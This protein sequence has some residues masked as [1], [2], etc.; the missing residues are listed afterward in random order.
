VADNDN[1]ISYVST[2][3]YAPNGA[4]TSLTNGSSNIL[5]SLAYNNRQQLCRV[6][7]NTSG[8]APTSCTDS[9]TGNVMDL[10]FS[11]VSGN[12]GNIAAENNNVSGASGRTQNYTYDP[13]NRL[14]SASTNAGSGGDCWGQQ[15]GNNATPPT[16]AD[17][18]LGN[19][20]VV[21]STECSTLA[22]SWSVNVHNQISNAG[23][24]YE[25]SGNMTSDAVDTYT[26][27]AENRINTAAGGTYCYLY[28]GDGLRVAKGT[29]Q[30]GYTCSS[31]G[32]NTP[33]MY[34][35]YWRDTNGVTLAETDGSGNTSNSSYHEY[36]FFAGQ[37]TARSDPSAGNVYYY[38]ADQLGSTRVLTNSSGSPCYEADFLPYG[39]ENTPSGFA[40]SCSTNYKFTGYERDPETGL[41][42]AFARYYNSRLGRFLSPDPLVLGDITN[43]Q[44]INR[45]TY[46]RNNPT[47]RVDPSGLCDDPEDP[48]CGGCDFFCGDPCFFCGGG[49][50]D[51]GPPASPYPPQQNPVSSSASTV[52]S[53]GGCDGSGDPTCGETN[54]IPYG[55]QFPG[56]SFPGLSGCTYGSGSCGGMIYAWTGQVGVSFNYT[57]WGLSLTWFAGIAV[58]LHRHVAFYH[59]RG[60]GVAEGQGASGGVQLGISNSDTVCGLGGP[61][62]NAS[63]TGG[64]DGLGGTADVFSGRGPGPGG[65]VTGGGVTIG[66][67]GGASASTAVTTTT[68][69]PVNG[70]TC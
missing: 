48:S 45:Y 22:P 8:T 57:W 1:N 17:D 41:D 13:L 21:S 30:S 32:A 38:F 67:A 63:G 68:V 65:Q 50:G 62:G 10:G 19:L 36:V 20:L 42:Y 58:D 26:F 16:L 54:G 23:Y 33:T 44:T 27:D 60:G 11:Y 6:A 55:L 43:P 61:F 35:L 37:R 66:V 3:Q 31:T 70:P 34:E 47:N 69:V 59:G 2:A 15:F 5:S 25:S 4:L 24:Y 46:V 51:G 28:D 49:G 40:N 29:P 18:N 39:A 53:Q 14:L 64:I 56:L 7:V 12:N 9:N 52:G